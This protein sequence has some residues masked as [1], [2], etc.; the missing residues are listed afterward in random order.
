MADPRLMRLL[1]GDALAGLRRRLRQRYERSMP[2]TFRLS[3]LTEAERNALAGLLGRKPRQADSMTLDVAGLDGALQRAGLAESLRD[4][5]ERLDGPIVDRAAERA[6]LQTQWTALRGR[7]DDARLS[8]LLELPRGMALVKRLARHPAAAGQLLDAAQAVVRAL[9]A[10]GMPRSRLAAEVLGDAHGLDPGR[11]VASIVL[12]AL[13]RNADAPEDVAGAE[14]N[15]RDLWAQA[16]VM[17]NELSRP[18][19]FLN[20]P[21]GDA[22]FRIPAPGEPGYVSLRTL[23]RQPPAWQV[24][25]RD[26]HVCENP[27]L[28]A[29]VADALGADAAPLV[30]TDGM[31]AA[32]QRTL[33]LQLAAAGACLHYHGDFDWPGLAIGNWVMRA[34]GAR[35]WRFGVADYLAALRDVP[36]RGRALGPESVDADWD[37]GLGPAMREHGRAVDE[38]AVA[39]MLVRDLEWTSQ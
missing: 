19:L 28:V 30:C 36:V 22:S 37:D 17:V 14:D 1:G 6:A 27:N 32:A 12:A 34:C 23:L 5:L 26:I 29:I 35:P 38:E 11:P 10:A 31:P 7:C 33:L 3:G 8:A 24:A 20:L 13:R 16:G 18:A 21:A 9:P 39:A 2:E 15:V 4:A 25:G